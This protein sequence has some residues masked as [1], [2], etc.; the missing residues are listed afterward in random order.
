MY[1]DLI[2]SIDTNIC[3]SKY[4]VCLTDKVIHNYIFIIPNKVNNN[5]L[6]SCYLAQGTL[7]GTSYIVVN[8]ISASKSL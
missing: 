6:I 5:L 8:T 7:L 1:E 4:L 2:H 3:I